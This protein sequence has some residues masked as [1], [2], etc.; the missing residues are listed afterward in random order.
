MYFTYYSD[1]EIMCNVSSSIQM[2]KLRV[3]IINWHFKKKILWAGLINESPLQSY[4]I[5]F[6]CNHVNICGKTRSYS[7]T[8]PLNITT[9]FM[10]ETCTQ[11]CSLPLIEYC[12]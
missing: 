11:S 9:C 5:L 1:D 7:V 2:S 10:A 3:T 4:V 12:V 8:F 6:T